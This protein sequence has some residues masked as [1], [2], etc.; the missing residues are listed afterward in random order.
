MGFIHKTFCEDCGAEVDD[1]FNHGPEVCSESPENDAKR[2]TEYAIWEKEFN[3]VNAAWE[4]WEDETG[5]LEHACPSVSQTPNEIA[6]EG[7]CLV[8]YFCEYE[9]EDA[10]GEPLG[11]YI[12]KVLENPTWGDIAREFDKAIPRVD[13]FHHIFLEGLR[14]INEVVDVTLPDNSVKVFHFSTGS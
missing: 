3:R 10:D 12:S 4:K 13:D 14:E 6:Y 5:K 9:G 1:V 7:K 2:K 11:N 8:I